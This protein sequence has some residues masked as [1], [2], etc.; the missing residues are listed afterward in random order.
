M[1]TGQAL[2]PVPVEELRSVR[3]GWP[4]VGGW[5]M[6]MARG[7]RTEIQVLEDDDETEQ[8]NGAWIEGPVQGIRSE[9]R[10]TLFFEACIRISWGK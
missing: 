1:T 10:H 5:E 2:D 7:E 8:G 9:S 4:A 6:H 3:P